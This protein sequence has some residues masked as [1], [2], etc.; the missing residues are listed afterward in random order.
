M[1]AILELILLSVFVGAMSGLHLAAQ[2]GPGA[3]ERYHLGGR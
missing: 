2:E 1:I 3:P